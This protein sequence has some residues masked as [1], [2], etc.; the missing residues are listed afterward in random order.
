MA[1]RVHALDHPAFVDDVARIVGQ[2]GDKLT[3]VM[4][5]K[6]ETVDQVDG[7]PRALDRAYGPRLPCMC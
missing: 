4:L 5:P 2:V 1:V 3:H 6:V 7:C